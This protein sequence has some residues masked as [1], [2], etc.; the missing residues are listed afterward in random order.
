MAA[1]APLAL[2]E[3]RSSSVD[4]RVPPHD[5]EAEAA[6]LSAV[7]C[8]PVA[9]D[10]VADIVRP[11]H[12]HSESHRRIFEAI[13]GVK[14]EGR[15]VDP[16]VVASWLRQHDRLAQVG[17]LSYITDILNK[18]PSTANYASYASIVVDQATIRRALFVCQ[19]YVALGYA[20]PES[21]DTYLNAIGAE[22]QAVSNG[23][24]RTTGE[25]IGPLVDSAILAA[26]EAQKSGARYTGL[27]TGFD[28]FD[29]MTGGLHEGDLTIIAAR[30]SM[31]KSALALNVAASVALAEKPRGVVVFSLE[32]P[33][34]QLAM[35]MLCSEGRVDV[36]RFRTGML[37][38]SDWTKLQAVNRALNRAPIWIDDQTNLSLVE[39]RARARRYMSEAEAKKISIALVVVDYLQLMRGERRTN[40]NREEEVSGLS[41]GLKTMAK[42]LGVPIVALAQLNRKN[43]ER[44]DKRPMLSDL[45]ESGAIEQDADNVVFIYRDEVYHPDTEDRNVAEIIIRKQRNGPPDTVRLRF[46]AQ[47]T[48]FDNLADGEYEDP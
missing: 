24:Q 25:M 12:F 28:R 44:T 11:E 46:D 27:E 33:K 14:A 29:R 35:R 42:D 15:D 20:S 38:S 31:G 32:M 18:A 36:A 17:G 26:A 48:R 9:L 37:S 13:M 47:Y 6:I 23:N 2:V 40:G 21:A 19:K 5:L 45:R 8:D 34:S 43:E 10:Q 1:A 39:M 16:V 7:L 3:E 4:V 41:R 22:L 30:P